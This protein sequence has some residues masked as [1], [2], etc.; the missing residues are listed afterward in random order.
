MEDNSTRLN[1]KVKLRLSFVYP[2]PLLQS[3]T[4][5]SLK[6]FPAYNH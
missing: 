5:N 2:L 1:E 6:L 3:E 4:T